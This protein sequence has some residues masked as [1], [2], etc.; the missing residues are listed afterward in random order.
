MR[1]SKLKFTQFKVYLT[2]DQFSPNRPM[3][4]AYYGFVFLSCVLE[5]IGSQSVVKKKIKCALKE[6][7]KSNPSITLCGSKSL[8]VAVVTNGKVKCAV[9]PLI[10]KAPCLGSRG[11]ED[12]NDVFSG[13]AAA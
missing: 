11:N 10:T 5:V 8:V 7:N 12:V 3:F 2:N 9:T 13:R 4:Y 1:W 6:Q